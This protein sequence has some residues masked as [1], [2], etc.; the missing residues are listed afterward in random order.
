MTNSTKLILTFCLSSAIDEEK[1]PGFLGFSLFLQ[2][3][4]VELN[5]S[6]ASEFLLPNSFQSIE[7]L[8]LYLE[9]SQGVWLVMWPHFKYDFANPTFN[10]LSDLLCSL[11]I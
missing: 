4:A 7:M 9:C 6:S 11:D 5:S 8:V 10:F 3:I 2:F 1:I